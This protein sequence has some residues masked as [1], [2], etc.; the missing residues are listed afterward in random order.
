MSLVVARIA[1]QVVPGVEVARA[2]SAASAR[3]GGEPA[4][5]PLPLAGRREGGPQAP[6]ARG[7]ETVAPVTSGLPQC[8][9]ELGTEF[10]QPLGPA[11]C[12]HQISPGRVQSM[13]GGS[14]GAR[15]GAGD[16]RRRPGSARPGPR[17]AGRRTPGTRAARRAPRPGDRDVVVGSPGGEPDRVI[18]EDLMKPGPREPATC[19]IPRAATAGS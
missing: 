8:A 7:A 6:V 11:G 1:G 3:N 10:L 9:A 4:R 13:G 14:A 2:W 5:T 17:R 18:Q 15:G 16:D 12:Q 19:A